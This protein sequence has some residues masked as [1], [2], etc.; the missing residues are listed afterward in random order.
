MSKNTNFEIGT[1]V[2]DTFLDSIQEMLTGA[3]HNVRLSPGTSS[4]QVALSLCGDIVNDGRAAVN[5]NGQYC[6]LDTTKDST[7]ASG[8]ASNKKIYLSTNANSSPLAPQFDV[9]ISASPPAASY[10]RQIGL[11]DYS[12]SQLSNARMLTGVQ[13]DHEQYNH[14]TF[15]SVYNVTNETL[16]TLDGQAAQVSAAG[17]NDSDISSTPTRAISITQGSDEFLYVDTAGRVVFVDQGFG[18][19]DAA[20]QYTVHGSNSVITSNKEFSSH[21]ATSGLPS[22]SARVVNTDDENRI[23]IY[24]NGQI[25]WGDG[26]DPADVG[27]SRT[28]IGELSLG[29]GNTLLMDYTITSSDSDD[30]VTNKEYVDASV[31]SSFSTS[32]R[33][34]F[35]IGS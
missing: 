15:R 10:L 19:G 1:I 34:S 32:K 14:F 17:A 23:T 6:Y 16:L 22:F 2:T 21:I 11:V 35:F 3:V 18:D 26:A 8:A 13:A 27:I 4:S 33:F 30:L 9:T 24:N 28:G 7:P 29:S 5:I 20:I 12:G 25:S 31:S